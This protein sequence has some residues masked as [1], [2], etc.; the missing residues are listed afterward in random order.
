ML[1]SYTLDYLLVVTR[2]VVTRMGVT[3][4]VVTRMDVTRMVVELI[5]LRFCRR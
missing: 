4:M 5:Q 3:R 2:M 1:L